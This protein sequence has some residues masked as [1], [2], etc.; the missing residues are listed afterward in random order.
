VCDLTL[1]V[2]SDCIALRGCLVEGNLRGVLLVLHIRH[3][4]HNGVLHN[5]A[6]HLSRPATVFSSMSLVLT[7]PEPAMVRSALQQHH[8]AVVMVHR[9]PQR[10]LKGMP[11]CGC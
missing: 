3:H 6:V 7:T 1:E 11:C 8:M 5:L 4:Q 9:S 10:A 2:T